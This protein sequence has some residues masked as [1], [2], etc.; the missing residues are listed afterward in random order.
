MSTVARSKSKQD[1]EAGVGNVYRADVT[2]NYWLHNGLYP[3]YRDKGCS[4]G[5]RNG[6][7]APS[8]CQSLKQMVNSETCPGK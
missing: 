7:I 1:E 4:G 8:M 3:T 5:G 2:V 6:N